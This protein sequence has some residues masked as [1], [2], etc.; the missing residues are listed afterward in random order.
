LGLAQGMD[1]RSVTEERVRN[2][3]RKLPSP[4]DAVIDRTK[5]ELERDEAIQ[6]Q[7][8]ASKRSRM[9]MRRGGNAAALVGSKHV[10][11]REHANDDATEPKNRLPP[12]TDN[13]LQR[14]YNADDR[15]RVISRRELDQR[16]RGTARRQ[17]QIVGNTRTITFDTSKANFKGRATE[18]R[19]YP[20]QQNQ[21]QL[22]LSLGAGLRTQKLNEELRALRSEKYE[23]DLRALATLEN[24]HTTTLQL[25]ADGAHLRLGRLDAAWDAR[26]QFLGPLA[27]RGQVV[28]W[29]WTK[30]FYVLCEGLLHEFRDQSLT[31]PLVAAWPVLGAKCCKAESTS[32]AHP[33][34]LAL[35]VS[36]YYVGESLLATVELAAETAV[37]RAEW[38]DAL[39]RASL[40][41][42]RLFRDGISD[43]ST[44]VAEVDVLDG[45]DAL[46]AA[47]VA[48]PPGAGEAIPARKRATGSAR[49]K[50]SRS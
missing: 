7:K 3:L 32:P 36:S 38:I 11:I 41:V 13:H 2:V 16:G 18:I 19:A 49:W 1:V 34:V 28:T 42:S 40:K 25:Q 9:K 39:E 23:S 27:K 15:K 46:H 4:L 6:L 43:K 50:L 14:R 10:E 29:R 12:A 44:H 26:L 48:P 21:S 22:L 5:A 47:T 20:H 24:L 35:T 31:S 33:Y 8:E 45:S 37:A 17:A 30:G